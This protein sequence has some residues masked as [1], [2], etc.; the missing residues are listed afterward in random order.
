MTN[1]HDVPAGDDRRIVAPFRDVRVL[2]LTGG[3]EVAHCTKILAE[4]GADVAFVEPA[5][6]HPLRTHGRSGARTH[7]RSGTRRSSAPLFSY[8]HAGKRSIVVG[9]GGGDA[10]IDDLLARVDVIVTND[11]PAPW[12]ELHARFPHL[13]AVVISPSVSM[14]PGPIVWPPISP[15]RRGW[16]HEAPGRRRWCAVDGRWRAE[17][18]VRRGPRGGES[19]RRAAEDRAERVSA[20]W[21]TSRC[22]NRPISSTGCTR[23]RLHPWRAGR[24]RAPAACRFPV[25]SRHSTDSSA[26]S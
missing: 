6:G 8:L 24:S 13:T 9:G 20:N 4:A 12:D 1:E 14:D 18:V 21:S 2:Q 10:E 3:I 5:E 25:S 19:A 22:W 17:P 7:G 11:V 26:S 15:C 16:R 23:S